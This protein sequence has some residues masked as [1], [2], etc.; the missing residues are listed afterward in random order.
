MK[1]F[2]EYILPK[3][4]DFFGNLHHQSEITKEVLDTLHNIYVDMSKTNEQLIAKIQEANKMRMSHLVELNSVMITPVDKEAISRIYV[5]LD[6]IVLS[7]KHLN[8]EISAHHISNL[9][10]YERMILLLKKQMIKMNDCFLNL[11]QKKYGELLS[12]V[13]SIIRM[14]DELI[15][16]YSVQVS[17]L[18]LKENI[19]DII[20]HKEI[21]TQLKEVSK[22]IHVCANSIEDIVFKL[23]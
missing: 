20:R 12:M 22:R 7:I 3:E 15:K 10:E 19:R 18:L 9:K 16:E 4:I 5:E 13:N 8:I 11:K 2:L 17:V 23:N 6:W 14:D 1:S 21:L